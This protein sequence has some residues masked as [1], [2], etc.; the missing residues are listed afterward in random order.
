MDHTITREQ[1]INAIRDELRSHPWARAMWLG[2]SDAT[3]RRDRFSDVDV[4]AV[5]EDAN[6]EDGFRVVK[7]AL[8]KLSP[9]DLEWRV[10][11]PTWHGH[12]QV[13]CRLRDADP[14]LFIDLVVIKKSAPPHLKFLETERHGEPVV[15]FDRDGFVARVPLDWPT[16]QQKLRARLERIRVTFPI[17]Q[18][19]VTRA[20][21]RGQP[22]DASYWYMQLTLVPLVELLRM[23][24]CPDR[25]DF[26]MRYLF[27]DLPPEWYRQVCEIVLPGSLDAMR[28]CRD[29]A[30]R[31]FNETLAMLDA[32]P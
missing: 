25:F 9:I 10:P 19:L 5:T 6:V 20:I 1:I 27:D 28:T 18:P 21:E 30:E 32:T 3:G 15:I 8:E 14:H 17:F 2:G 29:R 24:H 12:E 16:H 26:G 4:V 23:R 7:T 22:V 13:F 11:S 31:M